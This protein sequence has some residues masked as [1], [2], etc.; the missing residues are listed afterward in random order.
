MADDR[1]RWEL[2]VEMYATE[3]QARD[4][5]E[6]VQRL[7]CPDPDHRPPCPIPWSAHIYEAEGEDAAGLEQQYLI[8]HGGDSPD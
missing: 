3:E 2:R 8:E 4:I 6:Q 5:K 7:L 1:T